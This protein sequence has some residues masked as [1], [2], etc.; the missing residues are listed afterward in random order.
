MAGISDPLLDDEAVIGQGIDT[1]C[2]DADYL[3]TQIRGLSR[4]S[5]GLT[6]AGVATLVTC[7]LML[8]WSSG[9]VPLKELGQIDVPPG[10]TELLRGDPPGEN[11]GN[12]GVL[13]G[14]SGTQGAGYGS[15][16]RNAI[17]YMFSSVL[18]S[19]FLKVMAVASLLMGVGYAVVMNN[20]GMGVMAI[21]L[22]VGLGV[23]P[24]LMSSLIAPVD[25]GSGG[26]VNA[27]QSAGRRED[28]A[29]LNGLIARAR[30]T[31][32][33]QGQEVLGYVAAQVKAKAGEAGSEGERAWIGSLALKAAGANPAVVAFMERKLTGG[34]QS[35]LAVN[36]IKATK[37]EAD[38]FWKWGAIA[39][40]ASAACMLG[41]LVLYGIS[42]GMRLRLDDLTNGQASLAHPGER[43]QDP[44]VAQELG[45]RRRYSGRSWNTGAESAGRVSAAVPGSTLA[46]SYGSDEAAGMA[47]QVQVGAVCD[48]EAEPTAQGDCEGDVSDSSGSADNSSCGD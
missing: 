16:G 37:A 38:S 18:D 3:R 41:T 40:S 14:D 10:L 39:G 27:M 29:A 42:R 47:R 46:S 48:V 43:R 5:I 28:L 36:Y 24:G 4:V 7:V 33:V 31:A 32:G 20:V 13:A 2:D 22:A 17:E 44:A 35:A 1:Q 19:G 26:M 30:E 8:I 15:S 11:G 21:V 6:V 12:G 23:M 25:P 34:A 9:S 45:E